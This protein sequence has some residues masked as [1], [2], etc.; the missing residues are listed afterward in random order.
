MKIIASIVVSTQNNAPSVVEALCKRF[1][2]GRNGTEFAIKLPADHVQFDELIGLLQE[3]GLSQRDYARRGPRLPGEYSFDLHRHYDVQDSESAPFLR[4]VHTVLVS[5]D[6]ERDSEGRLIVQAFRLQPHFRIGC[7]LWEATIVRDDL[8]REMEA[9]RLQG[10]Q[11]H[12][13]NLIPPRNKARIRDK[14]GCLIREVELTDQDHVEK[15]GQFWE[16]TSSVTLPPIPDTNRLVCARDQSFTGD[17]SQVVGLKDDYRPPELNYRQSDLA[18]AGH[19]DF[20]L[21]FESFGKERWPVV[22]QRFYQ[23]CVKQE[24]KLDWIPVRI[25]P[26]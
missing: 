21:T 26:D 5:E 4:L 14:Q 17:Y 20:A 24:L 16:L 22:S 25:D 18:K 13:L 6:Q 11:F 2:S 10:L 23:F 15:Q 12:D 9:A 7:V 1:P 19:F 3:L 8:R